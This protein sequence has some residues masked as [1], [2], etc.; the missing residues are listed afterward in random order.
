MKNTIT[1]AIILAA[2]LGTRLKPI[3]D[4]SPKCLTEVNGKPVLLNTLE[5]L[6]ASGITQCTIVTGYLKDKITKTAGSSRNGVEIRY[7]ENRAYHKTNDMYSLW[8]AREVLVSGAVILEGDIFFRANTLK[9]ALRDMD[10]RSFYLAGRYPGKPDEVIL[11]TD[12]DKNIRSIEVLR[13]GAFLNACETG[14]NTFMSSGILTVRPEYGKSLHRWLQA[15]VD[16]GNTNVL[17]DDVIGMHATELPLSVYEIGDDDWV[18][19]DTPEDLYRAETIF[20]NDR[21]R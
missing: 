1:H 9:E 2:G 3:T 14:G 10:D 13:G 5:N 21:A 17:F 18:E 15:E 7:T 8:L 4:H 11:T 16:T 12:R 19:I 20:T 6:A